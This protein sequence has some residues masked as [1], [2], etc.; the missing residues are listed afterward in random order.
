MFATVR[1]AARDIGAAR[2]AIVN[3]IQRRESV[4]KRSSSIA[5]RTG[6]NWFCGPASSE[7]SPASI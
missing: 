3:L 2:I 6:S 7:I 4:H 1:S 5:A